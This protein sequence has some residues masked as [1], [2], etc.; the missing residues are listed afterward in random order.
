M[1]FINI[2]NGTELD[3]TSRWLIRKQAARFIFNT[4]SKSASFSNPPKQQ[5]STSRFRL[6]QKIIQSRSIQKVPAVRTKQF[7]EHDARPSQDESIPRKSDL[8]VI[9]QHGRNEFGEVPFT[10]V[11][12]QGSWDPFNALALQIT[13]RDQ[14]LMHFYCETAAF[15]P[16]VNFESLSTPWA[17]QL[18][19][20]SQ[21]TRAKIIANDAILQGIL[22]GRNTRW[23]L[24]P[25][26]PLA[27]LCNLSPSALDGVDRGKHSAP[28]GGDQDYH[29][30]TWGSVLEIWQWD[31]WCCILPSNIWGI[32]RT[33]SMTV[34]SNWN[35][36]RQMGYSQIWSIIWMECTR[37]FE[38]VE[39]LRAGNSLQISVDW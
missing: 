10:Y 16:F 39:D 23:S 3:N 32:V 1:Q 29:K 5:S 7:E 36:S 24:L 37:W 6:K 21:W 18:T 27:L 4:D 2:V 13:K 14:T 34:A 26:C 11:P 17:S 8:R 15:S 9:G 38:D 35:F 30:T 25:C 22:W 28:N 31:H 19:K 20:Y 12:S 33:H